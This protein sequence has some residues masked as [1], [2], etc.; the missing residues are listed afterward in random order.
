ME[1]Q[2]VRRIKRSFCIDT[3]SIKKATGEM[4][5]AFHTQQDT[6]LG[7][8]R[9]YIVNYLSKRGDISTGHILMVR[10]LPANEFGVPVEI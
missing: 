1:E 5:S 3:T 9:E 6:N 4:N 7:S 10:L 8:F 2:G